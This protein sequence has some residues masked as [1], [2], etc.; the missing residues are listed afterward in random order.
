MK[1]RTVHML[2]CIREPPFFQKKKQAT[3]ALRENGAGT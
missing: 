1:K 2:Y 3:T